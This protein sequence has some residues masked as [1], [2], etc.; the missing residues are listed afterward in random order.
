MLPV[1]LVAVLLEF[2]ADALTVTRVWTSNFVLVPLRCLLN[3]M[4]RK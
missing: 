1:D 3:Y 2:L 4:R